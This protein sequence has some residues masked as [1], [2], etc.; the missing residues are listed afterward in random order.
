MHTTNEDDKA[1]RRRFR[2]LPWVLWAVAVLTMVVA[3]FVTA[4]PHAPLR[5]EAAGQHRFR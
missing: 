5:E 4:R 1:P 2:R 3:D